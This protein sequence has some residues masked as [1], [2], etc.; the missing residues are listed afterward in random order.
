MRITDRRASTQPDPPKPRREPPGP[1]IHRRVAHVE[2]ASG[3]ICRAVLA[4]VERHKLTTTELLMILVAEQ[5]SWLKIALRTERH[6][7]DPDSPADVA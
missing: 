1:K 6:P 5:A 2:A 7:Q 3:D 4:A